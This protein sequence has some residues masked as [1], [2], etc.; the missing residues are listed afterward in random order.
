[1][2]KLLVKLT[3]FTKQESVFE[4]LNLNFKKWINSKQDNVKSYQ[5]IGKKL[6][7]CLGGSGGRVLLA[8]SN[9]AR[10]F[11]FTQNVFSS[12]TNDALKMQKIKYM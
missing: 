11:S 5:G 6:T 1:M 10:D 9:N 7:Y 3:K 12:S 4:N 2:L 8:L